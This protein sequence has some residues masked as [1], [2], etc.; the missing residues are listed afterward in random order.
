MERITSLCMMITT[1][2]GHKKLH[3]LADVVGDSLRAYVLDSNA[4]YT[5]INR[6]IIHPPTLTENFLDGTIA[7]FQWES[8]K[9]DEG[10]FWQ[11]TYTF[12]QPWIEVIESTCT[13]ARNVI[14]MIRDGVVWGDGTH[15]LLIC[16]G[17]D[18]EHMR[19]LHW[20]QSAMKMQN[21]QWTFDEKTRTV[22]IYD[23]QPSDV[24]EC[25]NWRMPDDK[26][27][28]YCQLK[29]ENPED[30]I[31]IRSVEE[32]IYTILNERIKAFSQ[33]GR[34][35]RQAAR[36]VLSNI[37]GTTVVSLIA[38]EMSCDMGQAEVYL[39]QYIDNA[40]GTLNIDDGDGKIYQALIENDAVLSHK[41]RLEVEKTWNASQASMISEQEA[42]K[43]AAEAVIKQLTQQ[44]ANLQEDIVSMEGQIRGQKEEISRYTALEIDIKEK[45]RMRIESA[46]ADMGSFLTELSVFLPSALQPAVEERT[47]DLNR[48]YLW[49][50]DVLLGSN[51][52]SV[53]VTENGEAVKANIMYNLECVGVVSDHLR[54]DFAAY[55][56]AA[57][58]LR[59]NLLL[60][61]AGSA[62]I[63]DALS[64]AVCQ[65]RA[66]RL[67]AEAGSDIQNAKIEI[68]ISHAQVIF[69]E[70]AFSAGKLE[71]LLAITEAFQD[72][73]F[74]FATPFPEALVIEPKGL[75]QYMLPIYTELYLIKPITGDFVFAD[76]SEALSTPGFHAKEINRIKS[77]LADFDKLVHLS[78]RQKH[79]IA[80][81]V[82]AMQGF[83]K[84]C[85]VKRSLAYALW[86]S[87]A[88]CTGRTSEAKELFALLEQ[89]DDEGRKE[90]NDFLDRSCL[91]AI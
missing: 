24:T 64:A 87:L 41:M 43:Q 6:D 30:T 71:G 14:S 72:R 67:S 88:V 5:D 55:L 76:A 44:T 53:D 21:S 45:V 59:V 19:A 74:I 26:R 39:R 27:K 25:K 80:Q 4:E 68:A 1:S 23:I 22:S 40:E 86:A 54:A 60:A 38:E 32:I 8:I 33:M 29:L 58:A 7:L 90:L 52:F 83:F 17:W 49:T 3:R 9:D 48:R 11:R 62:D 56:G 18:Q 69:I 31:S 50:D 78:A 47:N 70:N 42:R 82:C 35:A 57:F 16:F 85:A 81:L 36:S 15:D 77:K 89:I 73:M 65:S 51:E 2:K 84:N 34:K 75:Y 20:C 61:G 79:E 28:Y 63:A 13:S 46:R 10:R 66:A 91:N 12:N 37:D